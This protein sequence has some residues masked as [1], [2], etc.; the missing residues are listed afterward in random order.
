MSDY[1]HEAIQEWAWNYGEEHPERCWIL[2][3]F[4]VWVRN[5]HYH[6]EDQPHPEAY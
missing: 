4:D 2:H 6:G 3:F 1:V 5:P